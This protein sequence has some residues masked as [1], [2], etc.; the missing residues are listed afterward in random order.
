MLSVTAIM[1]RRDG[2]DVDDDARRSSSARPGLRG[3]TSPGA[4]ARV[5]GDAT[6]RRAG[7]LA[8]SITVETSAS[9]IADRP[10]GDDQRL[11]LAAYGEV[12]VGRE[13]AQFWRAPAKGCPV[14]LR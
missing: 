9:R 13:A 5:C 11:E 14:G 3:T 7:V 8:P 4:C 12:I 10:V 2:A 6:S 1:L